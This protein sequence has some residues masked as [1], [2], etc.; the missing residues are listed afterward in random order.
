[1]FVPFWV[2]YT[3]FGNIFYRQT[4]NTTILQIARDQLQELFLSSSNFTP[5]TLFI[6]TWER[7][8]QSRRASQ[9]SAYMWIFLLV[10]I[11]THCNNKRKLYV[12]AGRTW[13]KICQFFAWNSSHHNSWT[14]CSNWTAWRPRVAGTTSHYTNSAMKVCFVINVKGTWVRERTPTDACS[15]GQIIESF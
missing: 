15:P 10:T 1:M 3:M 12:N 9:V 4:D 7:V 13:D 2:T 11:T 8:A 14:I 6:A 5:A